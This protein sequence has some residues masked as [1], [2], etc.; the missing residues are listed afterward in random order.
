MIKRDL[1]RGSLVEKLAGQPSTVKGTPP[2]VFYCL[3]SE[4]FLSVPGGKFAPIW[5]K[6]FAKVLYMIIENP[7]G[8]KSL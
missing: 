7:H 1:K 6:S 2:L 3:F 8:C 5:L 4:R